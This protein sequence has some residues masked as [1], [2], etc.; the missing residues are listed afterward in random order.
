MKLRKFNLKTLTILS[1]NVEMDETEIKMPALCCMMGLAY[2]PNKK[3][4]NNI[5][6]KC[7]ERS[8]C[9]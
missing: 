6:T 1:T 7:Q 2:K 3:L 5:L 9:A 8:S 4:S